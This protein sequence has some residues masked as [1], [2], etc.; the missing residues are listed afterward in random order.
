MPDKLRVGVIGRTGKGNY[1]HGLDT[2]WTDVPQCEVVAVADEQ[3]AGRREAQKRTKAPVA[4]ADFR[5]ML[6]K[7]RLNIV[8]VA[9][10]W[11]DQHREM[12]LAAAE[13]GCHIYMEKPF[14][15]TPPAHAMRPE[16]AKV[17][18]CPASI[19]S[20]MPSSSLSRSR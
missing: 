19:A 2:V 5:E 17:C 10:R 16:L 3:E 18:P 13:H 1:G 6:D 7:E 15:P 11:I 9:P 12:A 14:V 20:T 4:Y 8:A